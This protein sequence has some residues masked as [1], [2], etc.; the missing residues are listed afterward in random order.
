MPTSPSPTPT[1]PSTSPAATFAKHA[2][3]ASSAKSTARWKATTTT[4]SAAP[5][6]ACP[7]TYAPTGCSAH[8]TS[9]ASCAT[10]MKAHLSTSPRATTPARGIRSCAT[11]DS[12]SNST[13]CNT[14]TSAPPPHSRPVS[15]SWHRYDPMPPPKREASS[16]SVWTMPPPTSMCPCIAPSSMCP[17]VSARATATST[18]IHPLPPSGPTT[19]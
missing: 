2:C 14:G 15:P 12:D 5:T 9:R 4:S 7:S 3:G 6:S 16:G 19:A 17:N 8:K 18:P 1:T 13:R 10:S 11:A